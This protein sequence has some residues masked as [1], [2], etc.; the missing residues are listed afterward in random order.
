MKHTHTI[1]AVIAS[2][3]LMG[4]A[5][6]QTNSLNPTLD[7]RKHVVL[8]AQIKATTLAPEEQ[9][10]AVAAA[11]S[12]FDLAQ[13]LAFIKDFHKGDASV[14]ARLAAAEEAGIGGSNVELSKLYLEDKLTIAGTSKIWWPTLSEELKLQA[15]AHVVAKAKFDVGDIFVVRSLA[16]NPEFDF[17][18]LKPRE[19]EL[20]AVL[21]KSSRAR[22]GLAH[23]LFCPNRS[24][25]TA[26]QYMKDQELLDVLESD[27]EARDY[28]FVRKEM[29][30][31]CIGAVTRTLRAAK[32]KDASAFDS[33]MVP[34]L[35]T[36]NA[37]LWAGLPAAMAP[38][39]MSLN[40]PDYCKLTDRLTFLCG[41]LDERKIT[42]SA[43]FAGSLMFW[44]GTEGYKSWI[45]DNTN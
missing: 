14:M 12:A 5:L 23:R 4:N 10:D 2:V 29:L 27:H 40:M 45:Q 39:G 6:A 37:P 38:Y 11:T 15:L 43:S 8:A 35:A 25:Q 1:A 17:T 30:A 44:K 19:A 18:D 42:T 16:S 34:I 41:Q 28:D 33:A 21:P 36:L 31:R 26:L 32:N 24:Q 13:D 9:G 20:M 7:Q 3:L 22:Y